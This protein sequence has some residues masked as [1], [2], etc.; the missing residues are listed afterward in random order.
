M[1]GAWISYDR[2][3]GLSSQAVLIDL[4]QRKAYFFSIIVWPEDLYY[5]TFLLILAAIG[6]F[7]ATSLFGRIW[8]GYT[9]P[10]TVMVDLFMMI[11]RIVQGD[12]NTRIKLDEI[13]MNG[14]K[15][16]K[17]LL[18]HF[19][20]ISVS[21]LFGFGWVGYFYDVRLLFNDLINFSISKNGLIWLLALTGTTY[22]FGGFLREKVCTHMCPYGRFQSGLFDSDTILVT[23]HEWRGEPRGKEALHGD[24]IDC[25]RCVIACPMG[26]DIRNGLQMPCIGCGLCIDAC[27]DVMKKMNRPLGLI[28]YTSENIAKKLQESWPKQSKNKVVLRPK[29]I[30]YISIF[31]LVFCALLA[32]LIMK[33]PIE[34]KVD[35]INSPLFTVTPFRSK[36]L[37]IQHPGHHQFHPRV[38]RAAAN[39]AFARAAASGVVRHS[40]GH[41]RAY[42]S[43]GSFRVASIPT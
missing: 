27:D 40:S 23:Y 35:K 43:P 24:C 10:H 39:N 8:C 1:V 22:L 2:G 38:S 42:P 32:S 12:R 25:K 17:K 11:E 16:I 31:L 5:L 41:P 3:N 37:L 14:E 9:C 19:L 15:L 34:L 4:P 7:I 18:T 36:P 29:V 26:I 20:W 13:P 21:F 30:F 28:Q 6:L 33:A